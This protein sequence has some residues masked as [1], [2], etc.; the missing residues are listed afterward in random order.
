MSRLIVNPCILSSEY[1]Q[2][3]FLFIIFLDDF[4]GGEQPYLSKK[5]SFIYTTQCVA[6][7]G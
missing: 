4:L 1:K 7:E 2:C 6:F 3:P 5:F